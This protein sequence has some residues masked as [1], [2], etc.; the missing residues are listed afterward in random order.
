MSSDLTQSGAI[1]TD[2]QVNNVRENCLSHVAESVPLANRDG[3][4]IA[5]YR[6]PSS[7]PLWNQSSPS[8]FFGPKGKRS[9]MVYYTTPVPLAGMSRQMYTCHV[10]EDDVLTFTISSA[11]KEFGGSA[12]AN[13]ATRRAGHD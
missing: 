12:R 8:N 10:G 13:R 6:M 1:P 9:G 3:L 5:L 4:E 2:E 11:R 7:N